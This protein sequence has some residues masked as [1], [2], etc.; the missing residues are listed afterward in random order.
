MTL[1]ISP[2]SFLDLQNQFGGSVPISLNEYYAGGG[3]TPANQ[4]GY[5]PITY[6]Q[7]ILSAIPASGTIGMYEFR[8]APYTSAAGSTTFYS[9]GTF[10]GK[11]GPNNAVTLDWFDNL[12]YHSVNYATIPAAS[13]TVTMGAAGN[14]SAFGTQTTNPFDMPVF[15]VYGNVDG[16]FYPRTVIYNSN[17]ISAGFQYTDLTPYTYGQNV[18]NGETFDNTVSGT[19]GFTD[20]NGNYYP[21]VRGLNAYFS[22]RFGIPFSSDSEGGHGELAHAVMIRRFPSA[23]AYGGTTYISYNEGRNNYYTLI[24]V[25]NSA[26]G[27]LR[28][29]NLDDSSGEGFYNT[30]INYKQPVW[31]RA[32]WS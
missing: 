5:I 28:F 13:Y 26:T 22:A 9:S 14:S 19:A 7:G 21:P 24:D 27:E 25:W 30:V 32:T 1:P 11:Y 6:T 18:W 29:R 4:Y 23:A 3:Y 20:K 2:I 16:G 15:Q 31:I 17:G 8:G 10:V 12:G